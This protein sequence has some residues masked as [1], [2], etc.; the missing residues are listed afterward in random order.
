MGS[1]GIPTRIEVASNSATHGT[2]TLQYVCHGQHHAAACVLCCGH[3]HSMHAWL[4]QHAFL[5]PPKIPK[6]LKDLHACNVGHT[7]RMPMGCA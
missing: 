4:L 6:R 3:T 5:H 1:G 7:P 2:C